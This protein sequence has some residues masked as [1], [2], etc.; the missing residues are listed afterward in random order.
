[1]LLKKKKKTTSQVEACYIALLD[2]HRQ[3]PIEKI[4]V[5]I[6]NVCACSRE[7]LT[8]KNIFLILY[9]YHMQLYRLLQ[10]FSGIA[11]VL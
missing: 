11:A 5:H 7:N 10:Y 2:S 1:M 3:F 9:A 6:I 4:R 8:T